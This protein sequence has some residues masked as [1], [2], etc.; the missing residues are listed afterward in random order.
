MWF[1]VLLIAGVMMLRDVWTE[2]RAHGHSLV[3]CVR[4]VTR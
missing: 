4:M 3:Y 2:C 1:G